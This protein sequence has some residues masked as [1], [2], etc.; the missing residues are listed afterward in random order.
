[1]SLHQGSGSQQQAAIRQIVEDISDPIVQIKCKFDTLSNAIAESKL[2][3]IDLLKLDA[4]LA[5]WEVLNLLRLE[6]WR[7]I[8]Q[9]AMEVH[10]WYD[11]M[12][13]FEFLKIRGF[14][15]VTSRKLKMGTSCVWAVK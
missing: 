7:R 2:E 14:R 4:E 8:R 10:I 11:A 1:V 9:F 6:D 13:I 12:P 15:R 5:D 3:S